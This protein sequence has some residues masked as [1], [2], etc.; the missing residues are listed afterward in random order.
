MKRLRHTHGHQEPNWDPDSPDFLLAQALPWP[1]LPPSLP[2][3]TRFGCIFKA[4]L[5]I[6][7]IY[8][9]TSIVSHAWEFSRLSADSQ[10]APWKHLPAK[11]RWPGL[12]P[13]QMDM[14]PDVG[15][16]ALLGT[17]LPCAGHPQAWC[18]VKRLLQEDIYWW[19]ISAP[20]FIFQRSHKS[21]DLSSVILIPAY[22]PHQVSEIEG[23]V[24]QTL[25]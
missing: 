17:H 22:V 19:E 16:W 24:Q 13:R 8:I 23:M 14:M 10:I 11:H 25:S 18:P 4:P 5:C 6:C 20:K 15:I 1:T 21:G 3:V 9:K 2:A 12:C 7:W